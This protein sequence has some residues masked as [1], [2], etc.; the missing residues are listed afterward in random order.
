MRLAQLREKH[1]GRW[2][3]G[4]LTHFARQAA[5]SKP[6]GLKHLLFALCDHYEPLWGGANDNQGR[7]RV[8]RWLRD[9]P[10]L[11]SD[12]RDGD[13]R[14]PRH[15]FFF[16]GEQYQPEFLDDLAQLTR[17]GHGEVELHLHHDG[18]SP[19]SLRAKINEYLAAFAR[20]GLLTRDATGRPRYGFIHGNWA[21]ANGR[22]DRRYC[23]VDEELS[24]LFE[25]GCYADF[26]FPAAPSE[27]QPRIVN[28]IY[29]P[30]GDLRRA[31]AYER[32]QRARVGDVRQDR[33]L[34]IQGPLAFSRRRPGYYPRVEN[35]ALTAKDP[36]TS[37]RVTTWVDQN[38]H[39][40]KRSDWV[41]VKV[42]THGAPEHQ[43]DSLLGSGGHQL[44][45]ALT[46]RFNDGVN[47]KL[48]YL[49]AREMFNVALAAMSGEQGDPSDYRDYRLVA[50]PVAS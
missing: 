40:A 14:S 38:I 5:T 6:K 35:G 3:W 2:A 21:L 16:P 10:V 43:A 27:C 12:Y 8:K 1:L 13:G 44:H 22:R 48:H 26:T 19:E 20:H 7:E 46:S 9:Y 17:T 36:A 49:T 4:Y 23:G 39:V 30:E 34:M 29:W 15:T 18:D 50:P 45:R 24:L 31:R 42:H 11:A 32:G 28:Q 33:I 41:F 37:P 47:W 25:T